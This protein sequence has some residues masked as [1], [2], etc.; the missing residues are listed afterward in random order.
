MSV[1][2]TLKYHYRSFCSVFLL[3]SC[4]FYG[5]IVSAYYNLKGQKQLGQYATARAYAYVMKKFVNVTV[6]VEGREF[7]DKSSPCI[8]ISNHQSTLDILMLGETW[9]KWCVV[10]AKR[11]LQW[12]PLLGWFMTLSGA[13]FL[14]RTNR[15]KSVTTLNKGLKEIIDIKGSVWIF[16]EGTRSYS[17]KLLMLPFKK[18]AFWLAKDGGIPIVPV[19]VSNTS[20]ISNAKT[21]SFNQGIIHVKVLAPMSLEHIE[22]KEDMNTFVDTVHDLMVKE[23]KENV[24]YATPI[25]D[26]DVPAEYK[27]WLSEK[28]ANNNAETFEK[29]DFSHKSTSSVQLSS[30]DESSE[31]TISRK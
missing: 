31:G 24:G 14:D 28:N 22:T 25:I 7:L 11:S 12:V 6:T 16:P 2:S 3:G 26:T 15:D 1:I 8:F 29:T 27:K 30:I 13:L 19:V 10:T 23:L 21:K 18:G 17:S 20:T 5:V 9:P 4:A